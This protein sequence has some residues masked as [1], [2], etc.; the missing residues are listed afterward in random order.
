MIELEASAVSRVSNNFTCILGVVVE[1][2]GR[3]RA[4]ST[5]DGGGGG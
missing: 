5:G 4:F 3:A 2:R 1:Y